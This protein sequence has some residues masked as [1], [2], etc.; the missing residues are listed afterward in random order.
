MPRRGDAAN[1]PSC[2][3]ESPDRQGP[4]RQA[5][6]ADARRS[7][8]PRRGPPL[9][10]ELLVLSAAYGSLHPAPALQGPIFHHVS[11]LDPGSVGTGLPPFKTCTQ[12]LL[13]VTCYSGGS[14]LR[15]WLDAYAGP[16]PQDPSRC[17]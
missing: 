16:L 5:P 4:D 13:T 14:Q 17:C 12:R 6:R 3:Q 2:F 9:Q 1:P 11:V 15:F 10:P 7:T 8:S